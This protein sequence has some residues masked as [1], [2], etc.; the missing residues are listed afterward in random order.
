MRKELRSIDSKAS[1]YAKQLKTAIDRRNFFV[2][3]ALSSFDFA[4]NQSIASKDLQKFFLYA[5]IAPSA[6]EVKAIRRH[7]RQGRIAKEDIVAELKAS[8]CVHRRSISR[9]FVRIRFA[10]HRLTGMQVRER[11]ERA[12]LGSLEKDT[13]ADARRSFRELR[14]PSFECPSCHKTFGLY[15]HYYTHQRSVH[16][17]KSLQRGAAECTILPRLLISLPDRRHKFQSMKQRQ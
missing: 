3:R 10:W 11:T 8:G 15:T 12:L 6:A 7:T 4:G 5:C 13:R 17:T 9:F 2:D 1:K 16:W 14:P